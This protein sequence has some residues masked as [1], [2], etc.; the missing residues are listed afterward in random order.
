MDPFNAFF[1]KFGGIFQLISLVAA[2]TALA[3]YVYNFIK[4]HESKVV[5]PKVEKEKMPKVKAEKVD[6]YNLIIKDEHNVVIYNT[7]YKSK[8]AAKSAVNK[9]V[10][11]LCKANKKP[12]LYKISK[13]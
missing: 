2:V 3:F 8:Y 13:I 11:E 7:N 5:K 9:V 10:K 1:S 6:R 12:N 4:T